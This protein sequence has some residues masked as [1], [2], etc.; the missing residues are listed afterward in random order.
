MIYF[1]VEENSSIV[2]ISLTRFS[3][4]HCQTLILYYIKEVYPRIPLM[5]WFPTLAVS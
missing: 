5:Q 2:G 4:V 1:K 3:N